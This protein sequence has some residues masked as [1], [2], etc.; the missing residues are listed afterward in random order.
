MN[1]A[2]LFSTL[3]PTLP[4]TLPV[5]EQKVKTETD[6]EKFVV[7]FLGEELFA[8]RASFVA[9][10][11]APPAVTPL[12]NA[13]AWLYGIANLRGSIISVLNLA[14]LCRK[15]NHLNSPKSKLIVLKPQ[16]NAPALA[17]PVERLSE[18]ITLAS[19]DIKTVED[20]RFF[21]KAFYQSASVSLID[22]EKL[23]STLS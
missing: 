7:F 23:F 11:L 14:L 13:P 5:N 9:E 18:M 20:E 22:A 8:I 4:E 17:F 1:N 12:P 21:G 2:E 10:V 3:S 19:K 16:T 6:G 15:K